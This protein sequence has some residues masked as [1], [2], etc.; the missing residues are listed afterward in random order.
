[1][2]AL[3]YEVT[4][5]NVDRRGTLTLEV[6]PSE[7]DDLLSRA[8]CTDVYYLRGYV[9]SAAETQS[10]RSSYLFLGDAGS[11]VAFPC[12]VREV[13]QSGVR[14]VTTVGYGGPLALGVDPPV[15]RFYAL[16]EQWCAEHDV[17]TTFARFHPLFENHR[18]AGPCFHRLQLDGTVSWPLDGDL[19]AG[20]HRHHRRLVRKAQ[21][22]DVEV[23]VTV[24]PDRLDDF[25]ALYEQTML[26]LGASSFYFFGE[27][28][29]RQLPRE[30]G[31]RI[32]LFEARHDGAT[33]GAAL[34]FAGAPWFH[35]HLGATSDAARELGVSHLLLYTAAC[36]AQ[37]HGYSQFHLGSG[38]GES[39]GS[40]LEFK[41]R[42]TPAPL[43][44]QWLGKAVHDVDRYLELTG[45]ETLAY[46][47]FFPAYRR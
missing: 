24:G 9:E 40:L 17:V 23:N 32:V 43:I 4:S 30:L 2:N 46:D 44:E 7:W 31:E 18:Y 36:F 11:C 37:T 29:W 42:F 34:C 1:M 38:L 19:F 41:R 25:S 47:G 26:R 16:Y 5:L 14:D 3:G 22:A 35:Y 27:E 33:L 39:G 28:Y 12:I 6:E 8:G 45:A 20:L 13:Q 10:G 21:A 15:E